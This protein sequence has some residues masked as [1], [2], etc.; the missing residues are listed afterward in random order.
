[1]ALSQDCLNLSCKGIT[2]V[3]KNNQQHVFSVTILNKKCNN[4]KTPDLFFKN[5]VI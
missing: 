4:I 3:Q 1:M 2:Y 5:K